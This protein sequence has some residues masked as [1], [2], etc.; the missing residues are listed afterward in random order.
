MH[1]SEEQLNE[2]LD[3]AT[4]ERAQIEAHLSSCDECA[5]RLSALQDLFLE[6]ES[7]PEVELA[8]ALAAPFTPRPSLPRRLEHSPHP[9]DISRRPAAK[10]ACGP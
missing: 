5:A 1:L 6:I 7:L 2:Y 9:S 8:R 10:S 4:D 3:E